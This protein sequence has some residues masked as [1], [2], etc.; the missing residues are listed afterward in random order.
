MAGK[1]PEAAKSRSVGG[2][3]WASLLPVCSRLAGSR[4]EISVLN[5]C[6]GAV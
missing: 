2:T 5:Y 4:T 6:P 3:L 1:E